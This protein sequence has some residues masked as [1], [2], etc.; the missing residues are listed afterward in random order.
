VKR[1]LM[2]LTVALLMVALIAANAAPAFAFNGSGKTP[3]GVKIGNK[4][5]NPHDGQ[6]A[7][8]RP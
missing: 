4:S 8:N 6:G 1:I 3:S 7:V 5:Q 2:I